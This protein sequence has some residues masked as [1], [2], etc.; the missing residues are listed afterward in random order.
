MV[1]LFGVGGRGGFLI[2]VKPFRTADWND[3]RLFVSQRRVDRILG[4]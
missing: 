4:R 1:L 2:L 3:F